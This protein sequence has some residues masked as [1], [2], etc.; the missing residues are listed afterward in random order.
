[1]LAAPYDRE[2]DDELAEYHAEEKFDGMRCQL[3]VSR[4]RVELYSRDLNSISKS[5]PELVDQF[6]LKSE[7]G[8]PEVLMDGEICVFTDNTIQSFQW[9]QKRMGVKNPTSKL[10]Q[11]YPV[12]FVAFDLLYHEGET[13]FKQPVAQRL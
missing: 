11:D 12:V 5:F 13:L 3:H 9:L 8:L 6:R 1:M 2:V 4:G 7:S 10:L